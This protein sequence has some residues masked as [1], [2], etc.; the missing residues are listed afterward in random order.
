M[1]RTLQVF[2]FYC[3]PLFFYY[4]LHINILIALAISSSFQF[5]QVLL[6]Y[7]EKCSN[8]TRA[9]HPPSFQ[10]R[11]IIFQLR[12]L[13][14]FLQQETKKKGRHDCNEKN[15]PPLQLMPGGTLMPFLRAGL[16]KCSWLRRLNI[17][18][19]TGI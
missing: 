18:L 10:G 16:S 4:V 8:P 7:L 14:P 19:L 15:I 13:D 9:V 1:K 2:S 6:L 3:F 11:L 17:F 12:A 5:L